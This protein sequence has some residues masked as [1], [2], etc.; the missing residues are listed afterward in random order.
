MWDEQSQSVHIP[1]EPDQTWCGYESVV[2]GGLIA[3]VLDEAMAW[4]VKQKSGAWAFTADFR[5][6]YKKAL[7]PFKKYTAV[8]RMDEESGRTIGAA[9]EILD[10]NGRVAAKASAVF[11]PSREAKPRTLENKSS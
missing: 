3:S 2:H 7:E 1:F 6:R 4:A 11:L 9:A 8:A 10:E 5:L